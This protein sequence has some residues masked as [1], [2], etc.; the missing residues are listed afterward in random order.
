MILVITLGSDVHLPREEREGMTSD[1]F[2]ISQ[3]EYRS[4]GAHACSS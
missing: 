4:D 2:D 3:L 1:I